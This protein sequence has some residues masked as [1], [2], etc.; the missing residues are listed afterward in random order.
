M[1]VGHFVEFINTAAALVRK[2]ERPR[3]QS[4]ISTSLSLQRYSQSRRC[5]RVTTH[6]D[7]CPTKQ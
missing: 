6:I 3:L 5:T 7:A 2:D 4:V 1:L